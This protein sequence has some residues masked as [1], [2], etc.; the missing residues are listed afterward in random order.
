MLIAGLPGSMRGVFQMIS[1]L[2][3]LSRQVCPLLQYRDRYTFT[4]FCLMPKRISITFNGMINGKK[5]CKFYSSSLHTI[6]QYT[7]HEHH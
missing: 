2:I 5:P 7:I 1:P 4:P 6:L 3:T